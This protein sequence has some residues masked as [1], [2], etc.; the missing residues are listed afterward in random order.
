MTPKNV[1]VLVVGGGTVGLSAALFLASQGLTPLVVERRAALSTH[2][3]ALGVG[4]RGLE[5]LRAAGVEPALH[6][7]PKR[8]PPTGRVQVSTLADPAPSAPPPTARA[9]WDRLERQSAAISPASGGDRAQDQLDPVLFEAAVGRGATVRFNVEASALAEDEDGVLVTLVNRDTRAEAVVHAR[10]VVAADGARSAVRQWCGIGTTGPGSFGS[11]MMNILFRADLRHLP[12]Y[13]PGSMHDIRNPRSS[14]L[15]FAVDGQHR[16]AFH[17]RYDPDAG[18]RPEDFPPE[19]CVEL[20]RE[21]IGR[22]DV[23]VEFLSALPWGSS[24]LVARKFAEGRVFLVGDAAHVL[25]PVGGFGLNTGIADADNLA[26]KLALVLTGRAGPELLHSYDAERRPLAEFTMAQVLLRG[27]NMRLHWDFGKVAERSALGIA[28]ILVAQVG[29]H[30]AEGAVINPRTA[31]P[32]LTEV[33]L[34]GTPG[35]RAPH[36]WVRHQGTRVSTL[37]LVAT[38]FTVLTGPEGHHWRAAAATATTA[39]GLPVT[40]HMIT[41]EEGPTQDPEGRWLTT[42]NLPPHG[43]LLVRPDGFVAW[44]R[45]TPPPDPTAALLA[46][47]R[48]LLRRE[49]VLQPA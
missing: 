12:S 18:E 31:L 13:R 46:A 30:Y 32:S 14:G 11:H 4:P 24:A 6:H 19:R 3:R 17:V 47:L 34:D 21:A 35:T 40:A 37:D 43:A 38:Q 25:P 41:R 8:P 48:H 16:H 2:P 9:D 49:E 42:T 1:D 23:D 33:V 20:V 29:H 27:T 26:W 7:T 36:V 44:R 10:Y 22:A 39:L 28:E 45:D 15:L 5:P